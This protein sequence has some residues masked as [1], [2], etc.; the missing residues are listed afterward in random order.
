MRKWNKKEVKS[1]SVSNI[2]DLLF[3]SMNQR[4]LEWISLQTSHLLRV[5]PEGPVSKTESTDEGKGPLFLPGNAWLVNHL[6][7]EHKNSNQILSKYIILFQ[8]IIYS[9]CGLICISNNSLFLLVRKSSKLFWLKSAF[10]PLLR[11]ANV[12]EHGRCRNGWVRETNL[13]NQVPWQMLH[14]VHLPLWFPKQQPTDALDLP[15]LSE[16]PA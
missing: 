12:K 7:I 13:T 8:Y 6:N 16:W 4:P 10:L 5:E 11:K 14:G 1:L 15:D 9:I 3:H 2:Q